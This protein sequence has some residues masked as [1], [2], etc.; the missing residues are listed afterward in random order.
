[1]KRMFSSDKKSFI[2]VVY[3]SSTLQDY[4]LKGQKKSTKK[5]KKEVKPY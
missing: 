3:S 2:L 1:M 4:E 5:Y